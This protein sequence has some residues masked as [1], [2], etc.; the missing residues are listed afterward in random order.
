MRLYAVLLGVIEKFTRFWG[1]GFGALR[2][3]SRLRD[4]ELCTKQGRHPAGFKVQGSEL[5]WKTPF[6]AT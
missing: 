5:W 6:K 3:T 2:V 4:R 1:F